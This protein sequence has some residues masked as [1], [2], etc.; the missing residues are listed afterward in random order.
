MCACVCVK[1]NEREK[2]RE[3]E[4]ERRVMNPG[5]L[6]DPGGKAREPGTAPAAPP[7]CSPP[8]VL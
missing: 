5:L 4:R 2:S 1:E 8:P 7:P 6:L 3:G